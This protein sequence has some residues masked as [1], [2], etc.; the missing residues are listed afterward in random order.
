MLSW[1]D[2][3]HC[4]TGWHIPGGC[5]RSRETLRERI[6]KTAREEI[7]CEVRY[8]PE[9]LHVFEIIDESERK[10]ADQRER[11]HFITL[12][13]ACRLPEDYDLAMQPK[14]AASPATFSGLRALPDDLLPLQQCYRRQWDTIQ[15]KM[16]R[17]EKN[18]EME[19]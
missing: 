1:R 14:N 13:A 16:R 3:V 10:L 17:I 6:Q 15:N 12:V 2:D 5:I 9:V 11:A 4:G 18:A 19:E 7:G 8:Y